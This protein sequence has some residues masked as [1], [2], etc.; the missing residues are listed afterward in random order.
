[1]TTKVKTSRRTANGADKLVAGRNGGFTLVE[2][3]A[4][5]AIVLLL[6]SLILG[7][8][9]GMVR[10]SAT[11]AGRDHLY[12]NLTLARQRAMMEGARTYLFVPNRNRYA[13]VQ[14]V[15][16]FGYVHGSNLYDFY[17]DLL[18]LAADSELIEDGA[19]RL[20][21]YNMDTGGEARIHRIEYPVDL[22][23][24]AGTDIPEAGERLTVSRMVAGSS[25]SIAGWLPGQRYGWQIGPTLHLPKG[26]RLDFESYPVYVTFYPD[27]S[28][29]GKEF[30]VI[31]E[32]RP[33]HPVVIEV[34]VSGGI[35][36][37]QDVADD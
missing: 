5:M 34:E 29:D 25:S 20:N 12:N 9:F 37:T 35:T 36:V 6:S 15:G 8:Y 14:S 33:N 32:I 11:V 3:M 13:I 31:E 28:S 2:L 10:G 1:M 19:A 24:P 21:I 30:R 16:R 27:G 22:R 4:V 17:A 7:G 26:F 18:K 23:V